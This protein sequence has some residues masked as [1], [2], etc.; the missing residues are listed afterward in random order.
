MIYAGC[1]FHKFKVIVNNRPNDHIYHSTETERILVTALLSTMPTLVGGFW[2]NDVPDD[3]PYMHNK[4][5]CKNYYGMI[6]KN[7]SSPSRQTIICTVVILL[8]AILLELLT[9]TSW[10][11]RNKFHRKNLDAEQPEAE[12]ALLPETPETVTEQPQPEDG[13]PAA[14]SPATA[15]STE[16]K[17]LDTRPVP[18]Y[19]FC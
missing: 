6:L 7:A 18:G 9:H 13:T 4:A 12:E 15:D 5:F 19:I 1:N 8:G 11:H 14:I 3:I 17:P 2:M 10:E 16:Q